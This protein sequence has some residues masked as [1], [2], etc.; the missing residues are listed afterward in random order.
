MLTQIS[1]E[2]FPREGRGNKIKL[3]IIL[4]PYGEAM[5]RGTRLC[6]VEG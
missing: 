4:P 3:W 1:V 2:R 6:L 5:G